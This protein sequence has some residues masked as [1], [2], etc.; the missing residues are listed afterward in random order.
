MAKKRK[1]LLEQVIK[2]TGGMYGDL[3]GVLGGKLAKVE[4]LELGDGL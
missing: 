4:Y 2:N 1:A 3:G